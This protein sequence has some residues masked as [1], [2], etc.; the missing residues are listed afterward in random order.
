VIVM[1]AAA[2]SGA[3]TAGVIVARGA[4]RVPRPALA[5]RHTVTVPK[6]GL[7]VPALRGVRLDLASARLAAAHLQRQID[8]GGLFGVLDD[9]NWVV[10]ATTPPATFPV[11]A[12][13]IV[14]VHVQRGC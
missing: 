3:V 6:P 5:A 2:L 9:T 8:G 7:V 10:C 11:V 12:G 1:I 13:T 14:V 4:S